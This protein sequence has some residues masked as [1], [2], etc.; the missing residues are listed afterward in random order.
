VIT[1]ARSNRQAARAL[2]TLAGVLAYTTLQWGGVVRTGRYQ[3]LLVLGP[4]AVLLSLSCPR[5][6][7]SPLP[8]CVL[9]KS[10]VQFGNSG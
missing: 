4:L 3:Y 10:E 8:D 6:E 2:L 5:D 9:R 7:W 1:E